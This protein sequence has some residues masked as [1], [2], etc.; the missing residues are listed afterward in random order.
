MFQYDRSHTISVKKVNENRREYDK[1]L[2]LRIETIDGDM[3]F[4][5][6]VAIFQLMGS[7]RI[8]VTKGKSQN[9]SNWQKNS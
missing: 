5:Q 9:T 3:T 6:K 2:S 1:G 8:P 4:L 7:A